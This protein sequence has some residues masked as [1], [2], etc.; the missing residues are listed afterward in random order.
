MMNSNHNGLDNDFDKKIVYFKSLL[1]GGLLLFL[2]SLTFHQSAIGR[3]ETAN[4]GIFLCHEIPEKMDC[5]TYDD[6]FYN[7]NPEFWHLPMGVGII[8][9]LG[10]TIALWLNW[11][12]NNAVKR[13]NLQLETMNK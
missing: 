4:V 5:N 11:T 2:I 6:M 3:Q 9:S 7:A 13:A 12:S 10:S 8:F 1:V